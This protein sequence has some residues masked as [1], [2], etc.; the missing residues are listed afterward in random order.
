M[1]F[2]WVIPFIFYAVT[3]A[4]TIGY[5]DAALILDNAHDL[6]ISAWV[7]NHNLFSVLG[8]LWMKVLPVGSEFFRI[9]LLS[10]IFGTFTV[11]FVFLTCL[12][13]TKTLWVSILSSLGLMTSHSLW[14]HS[15]ML[16]VY[17]LN[18]FLIAIILY[19]LM[20]YFA[21]H[22]K[23]WLFASLF[24]WGLGISNHVLMGLLVAAY[25]VLIIIERKNL[26]FPTYCVGFFC[27]IL[28]MSIF[29]F[30]F[31]KSFMRY[32][33]IIKVM[34]LLTGGEFRS[35]MFPATPKIFW[36]MNYIF[37]LIYQYPSLMIFFLF[38]GVVF[39]FIQRQKLDLIILAAVVPL[40]IWSANYLVWDMYAFS[41]P[42][43]VLLSMAIGKGLYLL[44]NRRKLILITC[45][46]MVLPFFLYKNVHR[47]SFIR[48]FIDRY[49]MV[50]MVKDSF[51]PIQYFLDPEKSQFNLVDQYV[52]ALFK[53][54]PEN[55]WYFDNAYDY[56]IRY[57]YQ[58]IRQERPDLHCPIIFV[59][60]VTEDEKS[61]V[62]R[63]INAQVN[64]QEPVYLSPFVFE[65]IRSQL[66]VQSIDKIRIQNRD[67][68][69]LH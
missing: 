34:D 24:F 21:T 10:A 6:R 11:Y 15:T 8:W 1:Q 5:V 59:F 14:W 9:N 60:W 54:L 50:E 35:L 58:E 48:T 53:E 20:K 37:L 12:E 41:L 13:Y 26:S 17:T 28:G 16:E 4:K 69:Q 63:Q 29:F 27:L 43:Y 23:N 39:L 65:L 52:Q 57:Y 64:L 19:A 44:K 25:I 55:A 30:A 18:T 45:I 68:Y 2:F 56:P 51:D 46:S 31:A 33:S 62:A 42:V 61:K 36:R 47:I 38:Y 7:N 32:R 3:M 66:N 67:I 49:P 40:I 22:Q